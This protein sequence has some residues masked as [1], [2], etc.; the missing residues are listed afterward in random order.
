MY[1]A[2]SLT[3]DQVAVAF[4]LRMFC[5][6]GRT[7]A[8]NLSKTNRSQTS[9]MTSMAVV[10]VVFVVEGKRVVSNGW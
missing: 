5:V 8:Q 7:V 1:V 2:P 9:S 3:L 4:L 6:A 10:V